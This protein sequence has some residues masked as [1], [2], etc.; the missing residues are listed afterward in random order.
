MSVLLIDI[1]IFEIRK[2]TLF[3]FK[4]QMPDI[5]PDTDWGPK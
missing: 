3:N 5:I 4:Y 2:F 1:K